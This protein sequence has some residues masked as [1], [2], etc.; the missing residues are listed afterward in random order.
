MEIEWR[1]VYFE[2]KPTGKKISNTGVM[3][4]EDGNPC[5][6]YDNG[7]G[8][9]AYVVGRRRDSKG[10]LQPKMEYIHRLVARYFLPNPNNLPQVN[11]KDCDKS[12]NIINNLE[13]ISRKDNID[14][15]HAEGRMKKRYENG[16]VVILTDAEVVE[17]YTRVK[18]GEGISVVARS[19]G[20]SRTTISSIINKRSRSNITDKIDKEFER[21]GT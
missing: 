12:N 18:N 8:Y 7:A 17:C 15:A 9:L 14:H 10:R 4:D 6:F 11:H 1:E 2:G 5:K 21:N 3:I 19:M 16:P 13:W 20:K